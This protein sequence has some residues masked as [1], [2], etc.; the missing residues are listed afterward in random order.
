MTPAGL[1]ARIVRSGV[2][3]K[4]LARLLGILQSN[5]S[6]W[7][8]G[9]RPIPAHHVAAIIR[10]TDNP[11]PRSEPA[12]RP[13]ADMPAGRSKGRGSKV[14]RQRRAARAERPE[15][16][17]GLGRDKSRGSL[18]RQRAAARAERPAKEAA[19]GHAREPD[20]PVDRRDDRQAEWDPVIDWPAALP[21][22]PEQPAHRL[23]PLAAG[24]DLS[25]VSALLKLAV[26][27]PSEVHSAGSAEPVRQPAGGVASPQRPPAAAQRVAPIPQPEAGMAGPLHAEFVRQAQP[28]AAAGRS[29]GNRV[30]AVYRAAAL[31]G[32]SAGAAAAAGCGRASGRAGSCAGCQGRRAGCKR[33]QGRAAGAG[34]GLPDALPQGW[35]LPMP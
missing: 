6:R 12:W 14:S 8:T 18:P 35:L 2:S 23:R 5:V 31:N 30:D 7:C 32:R 28:D 20:R 3:G 16:L 27:P 1:R 15:P 29:D 10:L 22:E 19:A 9:I 26:R 21:E 25:A 34:E 4:R 11:P 24:L 13:P 17:P 33:R